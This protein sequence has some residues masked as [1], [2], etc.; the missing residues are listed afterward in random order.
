MVALEGK[1]YDRWEQTDTDSFLCH[2]C[3]YCTVIQQNDT[4]WEDLGL[5]NYNIKFQRLGLE[6]KNVNSDYSKQLLRDKVNSIKFNYTMLNDYG[7]YRKHLKL[8]N[9]MPVPYP[10]IVN[11]DTDMI[12]K[13]VL[14]GRRFE[15]S[16]LM[17]DIHQ[18]HCCGMVQPH[19]SDDAFPDDAIFN[20]KIF[21]KTWLYSQSVPQGLA[22]RGPLCRHA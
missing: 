1:T 7:E 19:H 18:C 21:S 6:Y 15:S 13:H 14:L 16:M 12:D 2:L 20:K 22:E 3:K 5:R 9:K 11:M 4:P 17:Y 8:L 10:T